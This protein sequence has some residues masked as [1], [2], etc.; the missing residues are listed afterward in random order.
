MAKVS[1]KGSIVQLEKDKTKA[2]CRRWQ[3]RVNSGL[4]PRTGKYRTNTRRFSGTYTE[5]TKALREF[6][7]EIESNQVQD[8]TK[9]TLEEYCAR[10]VDRRETNKEIAAATA[11]KLRSNFRSACSHLGHANL[12]AITPEMLDEMYLAMLKGDTLSGRPS[13]GTHV[14]HIHNNLTLLFN[15][16]VKEGVLVTNPCLAANPPR[17]DTEERHA[18]EPD[19][20]RE[21][22]HELSGAGDSSCAYMLA[23]CMGMRRGEICGL[24]WGDVDFDAMTIH[25]RHSVDVANNLKGTKTKAGD[26]ILPMPD[27]V[28]D[29]LRTLRKSQGIRFDKLNRDRRKAGHYKGEPLVVT[30]ASPVISNISGRRLHPTTLSLWWRDERES[31][32][33]EGVTFH[34]LRHTYITMLAL[35]GVHPRLMQELAGHSD[36]Q[37]SMKVYTHVNLEAK[38]QA[39]STLSKAFVA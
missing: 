24:S 35:E 34:E 19:K 7:E 26:R 16:A 37:T 36:P 13:S 18:I 20:V 38:R 27:F 2:R 25:V 5:A 1:G 39:V 29:A 23:V 17:M 15:Q 4:N 14:R 28:A 33:L 22:V 11:R 10:Y 21:F 12:S 32:G 31:F 9:Y 30:D 3:L 8:R 6:I